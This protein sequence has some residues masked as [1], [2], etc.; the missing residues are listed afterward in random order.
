MEMELNVMGPTG[1]AQVKFDHDAAIVSW[2]ETSAPDRRLV[3]RLLEKA[4]SLGLKA[5]T[6]DQDTGALKAA[7][8]NPKLKEAGTLVLAGDPMAVRS[9]AKEIV[10]SEVSEGRLVM[11]SADGGRWEFVRPGEFKPEEAKKVVS[12][13]RVTGG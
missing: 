8:G 13:A 4:A 6:K 5:H 1:D 11:Q 3:K 10:D 9:L 2:K 7:E 12:S